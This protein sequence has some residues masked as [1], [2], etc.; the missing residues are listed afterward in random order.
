MSNPSSLLS[1]D[2]Q[3]G[4]VRAAL[5]VDEGDGCEGNDAVAEVQPLVLGAQR[6]V[7]CS[8]SACQ[9]WIGSFGRRIGNVAGSHLIG[10]QLV[11]V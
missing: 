9:L 2:V 8:S 6:Q 10:F 7:G 5:H 1:V 3:C 4:P 11:G